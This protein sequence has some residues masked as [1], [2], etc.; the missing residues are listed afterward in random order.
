M[1]SQ[2]VESGMS[3]Q[4]VVV[5]VPQLGVNDQVAT[6]VDWYVPD[7]DTVSIG[8][9]LCTLETTKAVFD[10]EAEA[11][12]HVVH[13]VDVGSEVR[14]SQP[15]ALIG[16]DL[17][18]LK[19][20][21]DRLANQIKAEISAQEA[22]RGSV[23]ATR[24][25]ISLARELGVNL[26]D[27]DVSGIVREREVRQFAAQLGESAKLGRE[28][29]VAPP[30]PNEDG[31]VT[32]E[33]LVKIENDSVFAQL[34]SDL[35]IYLYRLC[36][37]QIGDGVEIG[38][39]SI[40]LSQ[41]IR[42]SDNVEIGS[43]C[44]I[45]A[46]RLVLGKMSVIGDHARV[47]T[48]EIV[49]GDMFFSGNDILIGGGGA[50]GP[51]SSL[52]IGN[53]CLVSSNCVLNTGEPITI[54]D[55]VGLSPNVQFYTHNH[56]QNVLRGYLVRHAPI[57]VESGVYITG[58]CLVA[59]G[60]RI[61]EGATVLANSVVGADVA[62]YTVVSGVPARVVSH[63]NTDLTQFQKDHI[64]QHLMSEMAQMLQY[65][66]F[67]PEAVVY[68]STY[69]CQETLQAKVVL[70]FE[71]IDLPDSLEQPVI[72]NLSS[73]RVYGTQTRL[74]DEVRNFLRRR[75]VRFKPIHWRYTYDG[76]LYAQ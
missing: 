35:K 63:I 42:L 1:G 46:E 73:F 61:E 56:W 20:E 18:V 71:V 6:V 25:A 7:E 55:E 72:F 75:G 30:S 16:S 24:K 8:Y 36:G 32:P 58:N 14:V 29:W 60:V 13:L 28:T 31:F 44:Y 59:P 43:D 74:S 52:H 11:T 69:D 23:K 50:W 10:V 57:V 33:F 53:G 65:Q 12:G 27:I 15:M 51:R 62:S 9:P 64:V 66:G 47:V 37:A 68:A 41:V 48:K 45:K 40:I 76:G 22:T 34:D 2:E 26:V 54:G 4:I 67:D 39:G 70:T 17:K 3:E 19:A 5:T 49:I 21:K 38:K